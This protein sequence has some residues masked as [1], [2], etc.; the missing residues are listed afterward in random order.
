MSPDPG[1]MSLD[2]GLAAAEHYYWA[3]LSAQEFSEK[4]PP[5]FSAFVWT[6]ISLGYDALKW[7]AIAIEGPGELAS[8]SGMPSL[9]N[10]SLLGGASAPTLSSGWAAISGSWAGAF[11]ISGGSSCGCGSSSKVILR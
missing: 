3:A 7:V 2:P 1:A 9:G 6:T 5:L 8:Q 10:G 11:G 4:Y